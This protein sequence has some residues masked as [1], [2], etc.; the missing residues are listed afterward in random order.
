[1][2]LPRSCPCETSEKQTAQ[3]FSPADINYAARIAPQQVEGHRIARY[4]ERTRPEVKLTK[5]PSES[6]T[7]QSST[8]RYKMKMQRKCI[9]AL[10]IVVLWT[11][12]GIGLMTGL[13]MG[14]HELMATSGSCGLCNSE[15]ECGTK[16]QDYGS[17]T[18]TWCTESIGK[19]WWCIQM[20]DEERQSCGTCK[21]LRAGK[22]GRVIYR[23]INTGQVTDPN[24]PCDACITPADGTEC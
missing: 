16:L 7:W 9:G 20:P 22:C 3:I 13:R 17:T 1:M 15:G 14:P 21:D 11:S 4:D 23:D 24:E 12:A 5:R 8:G 19:V 6:M 18:Q 10:C 2:G